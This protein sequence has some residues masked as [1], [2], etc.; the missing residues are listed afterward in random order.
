MAKGGRK[1]SRYHSEGGRN[2]G[3]DSDRQTE[4]Y[5]GLGF[6]CLRKQ[7]VPMDSKNS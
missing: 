2:A 4:N 7:K 3:K 5:K 1:R 6:Q